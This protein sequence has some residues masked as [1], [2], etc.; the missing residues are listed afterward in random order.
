[1]LKRIVSLLILAVS[2]AACGGGSDN[3]TPAKRLEGEIFGPIHHVIDAEIR[4]NV[5][6]SG[7]LE[8]SRYLQKIGKA[9][10]LDFLFMFPILDR[11]AVRLVSNAEARL[12]EY[13]AQ[14]NDV[15]LP[16]V[17]LYLID[18]MYLGAALVQDDPVEYQAQLDDL[19]R[20]IALVR[21]RL[22]QA[23]LGISFSPHATLNNP[24]VMP[25]I[26]SAIALVDWV[27]TTSYWLGD[28]ATIPALHEWSR[29]FPMLAKHAQPTVET[30]Y[31]AQAFRAPSWDKQ[32]FREYMQ[33]ELQLSDAYDAIIFFGWQETSELSALT[34][35][36]L[37]EPETRTLY[38][39]FLNR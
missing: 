29:T 18:E 14:N 11:G 5:G 1:M 35:G 17:R 20:G 15:L 7:S 36:R 39:R 6:Y 10:V 23:R 12:D 4:S 24:K 30:W 9:N 13:I 19:K 26:Q 25:F 22:P 2:L 38:S 3:P 37:F 27:G 16:G 28:K 34:A 33:T 31:I 32:V 8:T 21:Q